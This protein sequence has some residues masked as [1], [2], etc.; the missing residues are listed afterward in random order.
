MGGRWA[1]AELPGMAV[2]ALASYTGGRLAQHVAAGLL[3]QEHLSNPPIF[4]HLP[5]QA[6]ELLDHLEGVLSNEPIEVRHCIYQLAPVQW[7][8]AGKQRTCPC[9][10]GHPAREGA[11]AWSPQFSAALRQNCGSL[12][13]PT[14]RPLLRRTLCRWCPAR[15]LL[16]SSRRCVGREGLCIRVPCASLCPGCMC[17]MPCLPAALASCSTY[18]CDRSAS[19]GAKPPVLP[20]PLL[21]LLPLTLLCY[22]PFPLP[23]REQGADC[24]AHPARRSGRRRPPRLC[25]LHRQRPV[26]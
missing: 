5:R 2:V 1:A 3:G 4:T 25:A 14:L 26:G 13:R 7:R 23:G 24:G 15:Q 18:D 12:H 22:V 9:G 19:A 21:A 11:H 8:C 10:D 16:R 20:L 6:K 17:A